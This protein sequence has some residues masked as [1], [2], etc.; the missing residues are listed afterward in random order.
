MEEIRISL[1]DCET[2]LRWVGIGTQDK[3]EE[4]TRW[5]TIYD[6][7]LIYVQEGE[8]VVQEEDATYILRPNDIHIMTPGR[9]H[10]R[11]TLG[12]Y[13]YYNFHFDILKKGEKHFDIDIVKMYLTNGEKVNG[14]VNRDFYYN[15]IE[16]AL[17]EKLKVNN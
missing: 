12:K 16:C 8:I 2:Y 3:A 13:K 6:Y 17:P 1:A 7:E 11:H 4:I 10:K 15:F 9:W 5:R 14:I